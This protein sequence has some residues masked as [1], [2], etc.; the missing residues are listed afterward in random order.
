[1]LLKAIGVEVA[2]PRR[3][4]RPRPRPARV[5]R[6]AIARRQAER[7]YLTAV[8]ALVRRVTAARAPFLAELGQVYTAI[9]STPESTVMQRVGSIGERYATTF[10]ELSADAHALAPPDGLEPIQEQLTGWIAALESACATLIH[11]RIRK[12]RGLLRDFRAELTLARRRAT[13]LQAAVAPYT[14]RRPL[15]PVAQPRPLSAAA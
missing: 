13:Q 15:Q 7:A 3:A 4:P 1:V 12:D 11:V 6:A 9:T 10:H 8:V 14:A 5:M 2:P